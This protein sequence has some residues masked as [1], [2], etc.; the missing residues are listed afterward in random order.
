[1][2]Q[3]KLLSFVWAQ[4]FGAKSN[5]FCSNVIFPSISV[6]ISGCTYQK[7]SLKPGQLLLYW[8]F[9][10]TVQFVSTAQ[11]ADL[12]SQLLKLRLHDGWGVHRQHG[13]LL[14]YYCL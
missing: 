8:K 3:G 12:Q 1:M 5:F 4:Y 10:P 6:N 14:H 13:R 2:V 7:M 11:C 9:V